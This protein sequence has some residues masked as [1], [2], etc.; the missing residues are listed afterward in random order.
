M[1]Q[2]RKGYKAT[3]VIKLQN[4]RSQLHYA[5]YY[6]NIR[7]M[8]FAMLAKYIC[9]WCY[10]KQVIGLQIENL[11]AFIF[12]CYY[13]NVSA[14]EPSCP[15]QVS[16]DP[17]KLQKISNYLIHGSRLFSFRLGHCA[18]WSSSAYRSEYPWGKFGWNM[19][20]YS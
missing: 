18:L 9:F 16:I 7:L 15:L 6:N 2:S 19:K 1:R 11:I 4:F 5:Q 13:H 20:R 14:V 8:P 17:R 3:L 12:W 10:D